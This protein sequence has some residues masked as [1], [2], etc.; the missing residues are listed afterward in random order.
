LRGLRTAKT[1]EVT[2]THCGGRNEVAQRAMSVFCAHCRKRLI[3]EDY[4]IKSYQAV[5]GYATCG[6]VVVQKQG[7]VAAPIQAANL[8]VKGVVQGDVRVRGKVD[9]AATGSISGKIVAPAINVS[10]GARLEAYCEIR[11]D[12]VETEL[13]NAGTIS[14]ADVAGT[15]PLSR[16]RA[17]TA[18]PKPAA[19]KRA[20]AAKAGEES[21]IS[22]EQPA[23]PAKK[24]VKKKTTTRSAKTK[25]AEKEP[26][27]TA[28]AKP[29]KKKTTARK[30]TT[31]KKKKTKSADS[32]SET[33]SATQPDADAETPAPKRQIKA[34]STRSRRTPTTGQR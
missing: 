18:P 7:R 16:T 23:Q 13:K 30:K 12:R 17:A 25:S 11:P 21:P 26:A 6:D 3:L 34:I 19:P 10:D 20:S 5:A 8:T 31:T 33:S 27:A 4:N 15:K 22:A 14:E 2:C 28:D 1:R 9:I 24:K 32:A 29:V